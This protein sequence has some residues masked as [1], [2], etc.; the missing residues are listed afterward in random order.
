MSNDISIQTFSEEYR[1]QALLLHERSFRSVS[2]ENYHNYAKRYQ[3]LLRPDRALL[4]VL[5]EKV[6]GLTSF[7][8]LDDDWDHGI[9]FVFLLTLPYLKESVLDRYLKGLMGLH[10]SEKGCYYEHMG[11]LPNLNSFAPPKESFIANAL[12]VDED[13]QRRH[14]GPDLAKRALE[15]VLEEYDPP[16]IFA[17]VIDGSPSVK[18]C[19]DLGL[20]PLIRFG[21]YYE[22]R[23]GTMI[24]GYNNT[25]GK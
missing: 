5:D 1:R 20:K 14:L 17:Q 3:Q 24:L 18:I 9:S 23:E 21:P 25:E 22:N 11:N 10:G 4:A 16:F 12:A 15:F 19:T 7:A 8:R 13:W 6:V 2:Q